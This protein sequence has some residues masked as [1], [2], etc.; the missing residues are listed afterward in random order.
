MIPVFKNI[1]LIGLGLIGGSLA[2]VIK[3]NGLAQKITGY[4]K[5]PESS[6]RALELGIIDSISKSNFQLAT[7]CDLIIISTP[8]STYDNIFQE[9]APAITGRTCII[10]DVG[11]IKLPAI[12]LAKKYFT[13]Q[14]LRY[15]VSA[16]PIAGTEKTG[17]ESGFAELFEEKKL[18]LT[19][20]EK[21][22]QNAIAIVSQFWEDCGSNIRILEAGAHD[23]IYAEV[24][25]LPQFLAYCY[26]TLLLENKEI[27]PSSATLSNNKNFQQFSRICSS[28]P[29]I[30]YD[31]F[32]MN[33]GYLASSL[34]NFTIT[35]LDAI[36]SIITETSGTHSD[37]NVVVANS[38][39]HEVPTL[40][41][42]ALVKCSP[43]APTYA[44]SGFKDFSSFH[45]NL[46]NPSDKSIALLAELLSKAQELL[47]LIKVGDDNKSMAFMQK[48][49]SW[50]KI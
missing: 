40:I 14:N 49:A 42:A 24:S 12:S 47:N 19:P 13:E 39:L 50:N 48:A 1:G 44:G 21:T 37:R 41:S 45:A 34:N 20:H 30:W 29:T 26:A 43:D 23:K 3:K 16:H 5:S 15:F 28:D 27:L 18:I 38:L 11:S 7:H 8:L 2:R 17:V 6:N 35:M 10:T 22:S 9:I 33:I 31:I 32:S 25:H 46:S 36:S 4:T